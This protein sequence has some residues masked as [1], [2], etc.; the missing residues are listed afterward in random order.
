MEGWWAWHF[1]LAGQTEFVSL[2]A[3]FQDAGTITTF[4]SHPDGS[5]ACMW[6]PGPDTLVSATAVVEGSGNLDLEFNLSHVCEGDP[7]QTT[8]SSTPPANPSST[9]PADPTPGPNTPEARPTTDSVPD[10]NDDPNTPNNSGKPKEGEQPAGGP[11]YAPP[12][13]EPPTTEPPANDPPAN[14]PPATP[15]AAT[16]A[17]GQPNDP[18]ADPDDRVA[19]ERVPSPNLAPAPPAADTGLAATGDQQT[20]VLG[21]LALVLAGLTTIFGVG[22]RQVAAT[23]R[24]RR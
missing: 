15:P 19:G 4:V 8:P 7:A 16:P 13:N 2:N 18:P 24:S 12:A 1:V 21:G 10:P 17:A 3:I 6:T 14:N 5:H 11:A 9:P 23:K 20:F 22:G